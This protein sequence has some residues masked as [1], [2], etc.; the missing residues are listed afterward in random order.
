MKAFVG[1]LVALVLVACSSSDDTPSTPRVGS[2]AGQCASREGATFV[3]KL[4]E[5]NGNCGLNGELVVQINAN[6][7]AGCTGTST[8]TADNCEVQ[9]DQECPSKSN[10]IAKIH[11]TG[12]GK[13]ST[14]GA[15]GTATENISLLDAANNVV[16]ASVVDIEYKRQ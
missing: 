2:G 9:Y 8:P 14:D 3:A 12:K 4:T 13:W 11:E 1:A 15:Y 5:R 10:G 6:T 16:C 7:G